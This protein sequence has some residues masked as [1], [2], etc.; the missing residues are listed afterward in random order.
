M[1]K[2][3]NPIIVKLG[4]SVI[5]VKGK[6]FTPNTI[7]IDRLAKEIAK[8]KLT[9]MIIIHGGGS[10]GHPLAKEYNIAG[11]YKTPTQMIGFSK[12]R[13]AMAA[14]NQIIIDCFIKY[15]LPAVTV[16]PS[17]CIITKKGRIQNFTFTSIQQLLNMGFIPVLYG[18]AVLDVDMGFTILSGDQLV[19]E[20][21][22]LFE[23][24]KIIIA[25][26]VDGVCTE[27]PKSNPNAKLIKEI[28][29]NELR[30]LL[31]SIGEAKT[32]DV[33][34]G[35][36]G[37]IIELIPALEHGISIKMVNA[38]KASCLYKA[39]KGEKV[40]GTEIKPW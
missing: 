16:Q 28:S 36:Y 24:V 4:G 13:Q 19:S 39:L 11:G 40:K 8:A 22:T 31:G 15:N 3:L 5:T 2:R 37:K 12:T 26:D 21:A 20:L 17:A 34:K 25:V 30:D 10:F 38:G 14:L 1:D 6:E 32:V 35:M 29:L 33:T 7:V 27:D 18:D 23:A 9:S